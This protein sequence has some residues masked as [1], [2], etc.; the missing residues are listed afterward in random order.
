MLFK[1]HHYWHD[2]RLESKVKITFFYIT[3]DSLTV[4][5]LC[6]VS[7]DD[8]DDILLISWV[9]LVSHQV[10]FLCNPSVVNVCYIALSRTSA[11]PTIWLLHRQTCT[12]SLC[13]FFFV[14][15]VWAC[16]STIIMLLVAFKQTVVHKYA[17]GPA[18]Y[19]SSELEHSNGVLSSHK[20]AY[21]DKIR[22][23]LVKYMFNWLWLTIL[24]V[25]S[26]CIL[27]KAQCNK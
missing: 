16:K 19:C 3:D 12:T 22:P 8:C 7:K 9:F 17:V 27:P 2:W 4:G 21:W 25:N 1:L 10:V 18:L 24:T 5:F 6:D 23:R 11:T 14:V 26:L 20:H 13:F 15:V